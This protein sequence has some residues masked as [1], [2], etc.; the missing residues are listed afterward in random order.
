MGVVWT[1]NASAAEAPA[2]ETPA[3]VAA[4]AA[5][6][7][8]EPVF[9]P[10]RLLPW[11]TKPK[12]L[13]R[14]KAG[15][16]SKAVAAAGADAAP[17]DTSGSL[18]PEPEY[19][20]K[21]LDGVEPVLTT[22]VPPAPP[23]MAKAVGEPDG[24]PDFYHAGY[25]QK[26]ETDGSWANLT[27]EQPKLLGGDYHTLAEIAVQ[28]GDDSHEHAVEVGWNVDRSVNGDADPHLFVYYWK[29]TVAQ[30]YNCDFVQYSKTVK[31]GDTLP[32][33][34]QKRF[35]IQHSGGAW[36]IAYN[37]EW[38][39]Y[40]PDSNWAGKYTKGG[41]VQWFGEVA[42]PDAVAPCSEM[43][44]KLPAIDGLAARIGS[45]SM[46]NGPVV[47]ME[48]LPTIPYYSM[49]FA[50]EVVPTTTTFRYGGVGASC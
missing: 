8:A 28:S 34:T 7:G 17:A 50:D 39:G 21:G 26:G 44:N 45:V 22:A 20:P 4:P 16:N 23:A 6:A 35:G 32:V 46:T 10:P 9:V 13:K 37:S 47:N 41:Q 5:D 49:K 36:W 29:G 48:E 1:L 42:S 24:K 14:A 25:K 19:G 31:P 2:V 15:A 40:F 11:G 18:V 33:N 43:G 30:C 38:I 27:I 3:V 12:K